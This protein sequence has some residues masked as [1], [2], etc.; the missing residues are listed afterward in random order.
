MTPEE[1]ELKA[2]RARRRKGSKI[3]KWEGDD[4]YSWALFIAGRVAYSGMDRGEA[5]WRRATATSRAES[6]DGHGLKKVKGGDLH[7]PPLIVSLQS[8]Q[9]I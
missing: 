9:P 1:T 7:P 2:A 4:R 3:E 5:K 6:C 8:C